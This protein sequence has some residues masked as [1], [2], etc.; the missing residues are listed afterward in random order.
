MFSATYRV[1]PSALS[2]RPLGAAPEIAI[3]PA[4][5]KVSGPADQPE[6]HQ[7][8]REQPPFPDES[9]RYS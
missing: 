2:D 1:V 8:E 6:D 7:Y 5:A 9:H 4:A 3:V